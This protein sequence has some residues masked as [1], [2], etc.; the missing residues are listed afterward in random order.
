MGPSSCRE[1]AKRE[2]HFKSDS[3]SS[4]PVEFAPIA[5]NLSLTL[6]NT[7]SIQRWGMIVDFSRRVF[8]HAFIV[9]V[10]YDSGVPLTSLNWLARNGIEGKRIG[11]KRSHVGHI[12]IWEINGF[13]R[14]NHNSVG[15]C[16]V[17][18]LPSLSQL[19]PLPLSW[20]YSA[21][22]F[23]RRLGALIVSVE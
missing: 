15:C 6:R 14:F 17:L 8:L 2:V 18:A 5:T 10:I 19:F 13:R 23:S 1:P 7:I 12:A 11:V 4:S 20:R 21:C 3:L 16:E 22:M 9:R